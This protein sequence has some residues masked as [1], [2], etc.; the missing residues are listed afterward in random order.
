MIDY[1]KLR[2]I[3][4]KLS[5]IEKELK[6]KLKKLNTSPDL[7]INKDYSY[8]IELSYLMK[9]DS[10]LDWKIIW[11][12]LDKDLEGKTI[13]DIIFDRFPKY[14]TIAQFK[15]KLNKIFS[16]VTSTKNI[17]NILFNFCLN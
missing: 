7:R 2:Q 3:N 14:K 1:D 12:H 16:K 11:K 17:E 5:I 6:I 10:Y 15:Q 4:E 9:Y 8:Q 13:V